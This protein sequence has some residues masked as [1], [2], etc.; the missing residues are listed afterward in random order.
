MVT[1]NDV[2]NVI[3]YV[4]INVCVALAR[5]AALLVALSNVQFLIACI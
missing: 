4:R 3:T 5:L 1:I 2:I